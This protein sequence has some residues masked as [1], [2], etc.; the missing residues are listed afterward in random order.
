MQVTNL[1]DGPW[2]AATM[3]IGEILDW[4]CLESTI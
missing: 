2:L 1:H 4:E 3:N